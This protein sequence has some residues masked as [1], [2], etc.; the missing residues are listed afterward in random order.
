MVLPQDMSPLRV[1]SQAPKWTVSITNRQ[2]SDKVRSLSAVRIDC[3][4]TDITPSSSLIANS[5]VLEDM[6]KKEVE[7]ND[8]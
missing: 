5:M 7:G 6:P 3:S 1:G 2:S 4:A 8:Q